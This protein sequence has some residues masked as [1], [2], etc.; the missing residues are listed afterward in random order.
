MSTDE[1]VEAA[2]LTPVPARP[3]RGPRILSRLAGRAPA[4]PPRGTILHNAGVAT[5]VMLTLAAAGSLIHEPILIPPLAATAAIVYGV[6]QLPLAQ[7]RSVIAGHMLCA[8]VGFAVLAVLGSSSW[9]AALAAGIGL[10]VMTAARTAHSPA[11]A[12]SVVIVLHSPHPAT[13]VPLL[14]GSATLLVLGGMAS[15]YARRGAPRYPVYWW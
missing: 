2:P 8:A 7:P 13:F 9:A 10:A 14:A 4:P 1:A 12:T 11:A 3:R 5:A 15:S 6:P